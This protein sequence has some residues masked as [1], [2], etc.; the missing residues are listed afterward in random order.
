MIKPII[1]KVKQIIRYFSFLLRIYTSSY[2]KKPDFIIVGT[3]KGGTSSLYKYLLQHPDILSALKKEIHYFDLNYDKRINHYLAYF[4]LR[5]PWN[6]K[7]ITGEASPYYMFHPH[8]IKRIAYHFPETKIIVLLRN[9]VTRAYSHYNHEKKLGREERSFDEIAGD[10]HDL[11]N[12]IKEW[13]SSIKDESYYSYE[14]H[15]HSYLLRGKYDFQIRNIFKHFDS[16][17]ILI[18]QSE[19]MFDEPNLV[20]KETIDFLG[21]S[22]VK[23]NNY[24]THNSNEYKSINE[25]TRKNLS[26][27]YS[28]HNEKLFNLIQK[29]F[30]WE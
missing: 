9:P 18:I 28:K 15:R 7:K 14:L 20:F 3:Q 1:Y 26:I 17:N 2:R 22:P 4:P 23:L 8:A 19:E 12:S 30:H 10:Q 16:S 24:T 27:C 5:L 11:I 21:L 25:K 13:Y 6:Q 29:R